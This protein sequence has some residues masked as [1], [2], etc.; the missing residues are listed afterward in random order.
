MLAVMLLLVGWH[1]VYN[2]HRLNVQIQSVVYN[3]WKTEQLSREAFGLSDENSRITLQVFLIEDHDEINRLLAQRLANTA[4]ISGLIEMIKPRLKSGEEKRLLD[5]VQATRTPYVD[6]YNQALTLLFT[7]TKQDEA[8]HMMVNNVQPRLTAYHNAWNAFDQYEIDAVEKIVQQGTIEYASDKQSFVILVILAGL[9][10]GG[11]AIFT[12]WRMG[13]E[14]AVRLHA[15]E[16]LRLE[17][18]QL[19]LRVLDRTAELARSNDEL[20]KAKEMA[21]AANVAKSASLINMAAAQRLAHVGSWEMELSNL[22]D[23]DANPLLWSDELFRI[24]G[25]E[26][27]T[28]E[29]RMKL[30]MHLVPENEHGAMRDALTAAIAR[31]QPY[32]LVHRLIRTNGEVRIVQELAQVFFEENT[33]RPLRIVGTTQDITERKRAEEQIVEQAKFLDEARD[34]IFV[35]D[36]KGKILFWNK[37]AE[38]LYGWTSAEV[39]GGYQ[40]EV[41]YANKKALEESYRATVSQGE[42]NGEL[43]H[44]T[45]DKR[46]LTIESRWTLIRDQEGNPK[47]VLAIN[48]D[49]TESKKI[50]AQFMR[51]QRM[52]SIGT[53]AGGVAHDLNNILA[54]ILMSIDILKTLSSHPQ[55]SKILETIE[56]SAKRGADI[57][58]QVLSFARG[59]EGERIEVQPKHLLKDLENI[60]QSTFPKNIR[61]HFS[62]P[63]DTWTILGDP[64]QVHQILLN[65]CVNARDAMPD[66]GSLTIG[67]ENCLLDEQYAAM[68]LQAKPGRYVKISVIDS[69]TGM[70]PEIVDKI[71]DPFFTTKQLHQ[72]TGLGLSTVLGIVKSHE[73]II[74]VSSTPGKGTTFNVY[75]PAMEMS[76]ASRTDQA[77]K[78]D[79]PRGNGETILVVDDESSILTITSQ[80]L[81]AF[82]Y[83]VLTAT[84]GAEAVSVY[85]KHQNEIAVVL[86]DMLMPIM[87]GSATIYALR[88]INPTVKIIAASGFNPTGSAAKPSGKGV[89]HFLIKPYTAETLLK[90][91]RSILDEA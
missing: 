80:T 78:A 22:T 15:E 2:L 39:L 26:P 19:E 42:W 74:N 6:S 66:G 31:R 30:V 69:G 87:D 91:I 61:M 88:R 55:A 11:I 46:E 20:Q 83:R 24:A 59:L 25:Y 72:G 34:A 64:T 68:N 37:G 52:E 9:M 63:N 75:L 48:T 41:L 7:E 57:V 27:G 84:D 44:F 28:V 43:Q 16:A 36:L 49:I 81:Q 77:E 62:L 45:K 29:P 79:L 10:T 35:R 54:P 21:E 17:H 33:G 4:R 38:R 50:E 65:L 70:P 82:G 73:G 51:A 67:V 40:D 71:F 89:E 8:R 18:G 86:T 3:H 23:L 12:V 53:L 1:G 76:P 85:A 47:S 60:I 56:V 58:R 5:D 32:S 14:V 13:R 90:T